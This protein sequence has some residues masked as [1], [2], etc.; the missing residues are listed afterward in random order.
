MNSNAAIKDNQR[1]RIK[2][3]GAFSAFVPIPE[4][5]GRHRAAPF[6][7]LAPES[8]LGSLASVALP[9]AQVSVMVAGR[10]VG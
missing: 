6:R 1:P 2:S 7:S 3:D 4:A 9:S 10:K 8:A 5:E